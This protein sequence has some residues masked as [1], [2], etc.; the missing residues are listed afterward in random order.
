MG[1]TNCVKKIGYRP[2]RVV[3]GTSAV[4]IGILV[5]HLTFCV[6]FGTAAGLFPGSQTSAGHGHRRRPAQRLDLRPRVRRRR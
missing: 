4:W 2:N 6:L 3:T 5:A 1:Q